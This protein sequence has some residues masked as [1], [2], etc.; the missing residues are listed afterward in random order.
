MNGTTS[1]H[2]IGSLSS[3]TGVPVRTIRFYS[4]I[5][6]LPPTHRTPAG[7]RSYDDAALIRL[8]TI[9]A[10][11]ELD[12]DLATIRRVLGGD[13]S[14][15]E[16]AAAQADAAELQI[17]MLRLRQSVLRHLARRGYDPEETALVHRLIRLTSEERRRP[18]TRTPCRGSLPGRRRSSSPSPARRSPPRGNR[19]PIRRTRGP[20]RWSMPSWHAS[21]PPSAALSGPG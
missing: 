17:R 5:G 16:V 1:P 21:P 10:L 18:P 12:V 3:R 9:C 7:Y 8:R 2:S 4:D 20:R 13:L 6:L 15:A 19:A 11:R 14:V